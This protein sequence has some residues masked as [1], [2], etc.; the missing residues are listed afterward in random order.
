MDREL[1]EA[2][3]QG[4]LFRV[5]EF[6]KQCADWNYGMCGA[7]QGGHK[8]L[9]DLFVKNG[10]NDWNRGMYGAVKGGH[11]ELVDLFVKNGANAW[12]WG[13][14]DAA[15]GGYKE[16]VDLFVKKGANNWNCGLELSNTPSLKI[17][18]IDQGADIIAHFP[19]FYKDICRLYH[20]PNGIL[21]NKLLRR[22]IALFKGSKLRN[23]KVIINDIYETTLDQVFISPPGTIV[24]FRNETHVIK[25]HI[26]YLLK[27]RNP[28]FK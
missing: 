22:Y 23:E 16:L 5:N 4:S 19:L 20:L 13:M 6:I 8:E 3:R 27:S 7:A 17:F 26:F 15:K 25:G 14:C 1:Y 24:K 21:I 18:F 2:A 12:N 9:V 28:Q 10:A 11:K